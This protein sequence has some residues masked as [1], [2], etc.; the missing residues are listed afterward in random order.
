MNLRAL[1][2]SPAL[3]GLLLAAAAG[4]SFI[5]VPAAQTSAPAAYTAKCS[6]CHGPALQGTAHGPQLTGGDFKDNWGSRGGE[7]LP[8][9]KNRMPP[10]EAGSLPDAD[11][12]AIAAFILQT[13]GIAGPA[14][15]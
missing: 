2:A 13:N 6:S 4:V 3:R 7:L 8:F 9:I 15:A 14:A 12:T 5:S 1:H 11:Y 10:G